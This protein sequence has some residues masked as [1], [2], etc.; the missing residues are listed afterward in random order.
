MRIHTNIYN[1]TGIKELVIPI[2]SELTDFY[3]FNQ[4]KLLLQAVQSGGDAISKIMVFKRNSIK[5]FQA[6]A[7]LMSLIKTF[8]NHYNDDLDNQISLNFFQ[9][10]GN[11]TIPSPKIPAFFKDTITTN[12]IEDILSIIDDDILMEAV[13][14]ILHH[15]DLNSNIF[16]F[17]T[18]LKDERSVIQGNLNGTFSSFRSLAHE[19]GH[20]LYEKNHDYHSIYGLILSELFA[21]IFEQFISEALLFQKKY[22]KVHIL[23]NREYC[24]NLFIIDQLFYKKELSEL[25]K[26][27]TSFFCIDEELCVFRPSYF[28]GT[29]LQIIC[30]QSSMLFFQIITALCIENCEHVFKIYNELIQH[31]KAFDISLLNF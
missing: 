24:R 30:G 1:I 29:G 19:L 27:N 5:Y 23:E 15:S 28:Y 10:V 11:K 8:S 13:K 22:N 26:K 17:R 18:V 6:N 9:K 4:K 7:K 21:L 25:L 16:G 12:P 3:I 20:C 31:T 2:Y 14:E